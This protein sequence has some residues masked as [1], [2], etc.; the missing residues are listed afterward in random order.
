MFVRDRDALGRVDLG[1]IE[2]LIGFV[3]A[4]RQLPRHAYLYDFGFV[5][6]H[7]SLAV[8]YYDVCPQRGT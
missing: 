1:Q 3:R 2:L 4:S 8:G 5:A 7:V 6:M